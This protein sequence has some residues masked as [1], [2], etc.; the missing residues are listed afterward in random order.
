[1]KNKTFKYLTIDFNKNVFFLLIIS[2]LFSIA[3]DALHFLYPIIQKK[4]INI[5]IENKVFGKNIFIQLIILVSFVIIFSFMSRTLLQVF[6]KKFSINRNTHHL[7]LISY[8]DFKAISQYGTGYIANIFENNFFDYYM[9]HLT[10]TSIK[11]FL[12]SVVFGISAFFIIFRWSK[13]IAIICLLQ[14][15]ISSLL[16]VKYMQITKENR[17]TQLEK[18]SGTIKLLNQYLICF[19]LYKFYSS[20]SFFN[21]KYEKKF[22][23][24]LGSFIKNFR[25]NT[26]FNWTFLK[27]FSDAF[28]LL[29]IVIMIMDYIN[30]KIDFGTI[31]AIQ[32]YKTYFNSIFNNYYNVLQEINSFKYNFETYYEKIY[33]KVIMP[34]ENILLQKTNFF[35]G[36]ENNCIVE[37]KNLNINYNGKSII[38]NLNF[39]LFEN[40]KLGLVGLSGEGKSS[41][42]K[43]LFKHSKSYTGEVLINSHNIINI[44][45]NYIYNRINYFS[46]SIQIIDDNLEN[47]ICFGK[48]L[49]SETKLKEIKETKYNDF[50][51]LINKFVLDLDKS[52]KKKNF[53]K[54]IDKNKELFKNL[55]FAGFIPDS[56][57]FKYIKLENK[58]E[59]LE[60]YIESVYKFFEEYNSDYIAT[61]I[62]NF[63]I[64]TRY[65]DSKKYN[66][67]IKLL[68]IESLDGRN[69]GE[70]GE[71]ISGGEKHRIAIARFLLKEDFDYFILDEPFANLDSIIEKKLINITKEKL[72]GKSGII[73]SH[74]FNVLKH[75]ADDFIVLEDGT[76]SQSGTHQELINGEGLYKNLFETFNMVRV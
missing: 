56:F 71:F 9:N 27:L 64:N 75:L 76:I 68:E 24:S 26:I 42:I 40:H 55:E 20:E 8:S 54:I 72:E 21:K 12:V 35:R 51:F 57:L 5:S 16:T 52:K 60:K 63:F 37:T 44:P 11:D 6:T 53:A 4:F 39:K 33:D 34:L 61:K 49:V 7:K 73:I 46:Q 62:T 48:K 29:I 45:N 69:F 17:K 23:K 36:R 30:A 31:L 15:L 32:M 58:T 1:M 22:D 10:F 41:I 43:T 59:L 47:N 38:N 3:V 13:Y 14:L 25:L 28:D 18:T 67:V 2:L 70:N 19:P 66:E 65:I 74:N 50:I